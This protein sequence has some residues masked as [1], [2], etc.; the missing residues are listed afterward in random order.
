M[1]V[2]LLIPSHR[3]L[4]S[5][6]FGLPASRG[7]AQLLL[8]KTISPREG[9]PGISPQR[10]QG[11]R[12]VSSVAGAPTKGNAPSGLKCTPSM[13][14][15]CVASQMHTPEYGPERTAPDSRLYRSGWN[16][17]VVPNFILAQIDYQF[18]CS[19]GEN[20][21]FSI[22]LA[23]RDHPKETH[24]FVK[25]PYRPN[26]RS[27][28]CIKGLLVQKHERHLNVRVS[29]IGI[30]DHRSPPSPCLVSSRPY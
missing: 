29:S 28:P 22:H 14:W 30:R 9:G 10:A 15:C 20:S 21:F 3:K 2:G 23:A 13:D 5:R 26:L 17:I 18:R 16:R 1:G 24:K 6:S 19:V 11:L 12:S 7:F 25:R 4:P 27:G 8:L